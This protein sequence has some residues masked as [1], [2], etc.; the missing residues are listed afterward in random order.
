MSC[1]QH[2]ISRRDS[3]LLCRNSPVLLAFLGT[4]CETAAFQCRA[5]CCSED[6]AW[7]LHF[8][9]T[10]AR[11]SYTSTV[12]EATAVHLMARRSCL[13]CLR[14]NPA[15]M[16]P[17]AL[18]NNNF[19]HVVLRQ[20]RTAG[21]PRSRQ[22]GLVGGIVAF[23]QDGGPLLDLLPR[24]AGELAEYFSVAFSSDDS[25]KVR[26]RRALLVRRT[27]VAAALRWLKQHNLHYADVCIS[28]DNLA[29]LSESAVPGVLFLQA[30]SAGEAAHNEQGHFFSCTGLDFGVGRSAFQL[31][32]FSLSGPANA[33]GEPDSSSALLNAA[34]IDVAG[35]AP[36]RALRAWEDLSQATTNMSMYLE[37]QPSDILAAA[38]Q[39]AHA[40]EAMSGLTSGQAATDMEAATRAESGDAPDDSRHVGIVPHSS[41][42]LSSYDPSYWP[43]CHPL[44]FPYMG[45][46]VMGL[47][48]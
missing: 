12:G 40:Q 18:A 31:A 35:S 21:D 44:H 8:P 36:C 19:S 30:V 6:D 46:E 37:R 11:A 3:A 28:E 20:L 29:A 4:V 47:A 24:R 14:A 5:I 34:C 42:P 38:L 32:G 17:L 23:P 25:D 33:A 13:P 45:S 16:P 7:L 27:R 26:S 9:T 15:R 10:A 39:A 1:C 41:V 48:A 2:A 43:L 22:Q